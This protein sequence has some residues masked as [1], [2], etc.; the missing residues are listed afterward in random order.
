MQKDEVMVGC[1]V[2]CERQNKSLFIVPIKR[3]LWIEERSRGVVGRMKR[4]ILMWS[5]SGRCKEECEDDV[6]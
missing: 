1:C 5:M 3:M 4:T 6:R 2:F